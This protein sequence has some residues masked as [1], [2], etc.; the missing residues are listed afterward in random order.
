MEQSFQQTDNTA[1]PRPV[2]HQNHSI[3][4]RRVGRMATRPMAS[5]LAESTSAALELTRRAAELGADFALVI[6]PH[7]Y[8]GQMDRAALVRHYRS[9]ADA[10]PIPIL[11]YNVPPNTNI[12]MD[13]ATII[14]LDSRP[15]S[16]RGCK[17]ATMTTLRPISD[18]GL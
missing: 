12:D 10:S 17:L 5:A 16:L 7:Y 9:V 6:T 1:A 4:Q 13:A 8:R 11:L 3:A 2:S 18:S 15:R 14:P